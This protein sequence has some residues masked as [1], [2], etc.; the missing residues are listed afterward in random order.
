MV[1]FINDN[2]KGHDE[3]RGSI[4]R[5]GR[6]F[7]H[8]GTSGNTSLCAEWNLWS[9]RL[10]AGL[11]LADY[12]HAISAHLCT[13]L[14]SL[15]LILNYWPLE[16]WLQRITKRKHEKYGNGRTVG[17]SWFEGSLRVDIWNC[18]ME[19]HSTDPKWWSFSINPVDLLL[20]SR[21][22]SERTIQSGIRQLTF[23]EKTY[24]VRIDI[25]EATWKRPRWP[26]A[27]KI[28][29]TDAEVD[30][31]IP[32]PGKGTTDCNCDDDAIYSQTSPGATFDA[33]LTS[34]FRSVSYAREHYPL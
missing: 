17:L 27:T 9:K 29:R 2:T 6:M 25:K 21:E 20:G 28:L 19:W 8:I 7:W 16:Q 31:G 23:P 14:F 32:V 26:W 18:P 15:Y 5:S 22:Y 10:S 30:G 34:L 3:V 1:H 33:A 4:I 13:Y 12:D 24:D 11:G